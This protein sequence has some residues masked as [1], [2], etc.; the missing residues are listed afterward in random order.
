VTAMVNPQHPDSRYPHR[1]LCGVAVAFK[2]TQALCRMAPEVVPPSFPETV[3]DLVTLGVIADQMPLVGENRVLVKKGLERLGRRLHARPGLDALL[4]VAGLDQGLP[5]SASDLAYQVIPRLNACGRIGRVMTA[6]E[7]LLCRDVGV[8]RDLA[9]EADRTNLLRRQADQAL[10]AEAVEMA[11][12]FLDQGDRGLVLHSPDW[13]KGIIG[14]GASRLV[15][16]YQ[17]PTVLIATDGEQARGSARSTSNID[18]KTVLDHCAHT[19]I[20]YGGHAQAAGLSLRTQDIE[21]FRQAFLAALEAGPATGP[22]PEPYDLDLPLARLTA[23]DVSQLFGEL[24]LLEPF[25]MG[26][27]RPVFRS[28]GLRLLRWPQPLSGGLHLRFAFSGPDESPSQGSP[29]LLREF[30]CFGGGP[31]WQDW[32]ATTGAGAQD[33]RA[34]RWDLLFQLNRS[35]YRLHGDQYD[36]VQQLLVDLRPAQS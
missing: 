29:A 21:T 33:P 25:G 20:R 1:D 12:P 27:Q 18:V 8:A 34:R 16:K 13:H 30:I 2:L 36:P 17:V 22:S 3:L 28:C 24:E 14:I 11:G 31:A 6:L 35:T 5:P 9:R 32:L 19:L 4:A 15:E 10:K 7:L 26:N 23:G